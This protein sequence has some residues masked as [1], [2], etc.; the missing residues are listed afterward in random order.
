MTHAD[1]VAI[2]VARRIA[3]ECHAASAMARPQS[4]GD[5]VITAYLGGYC[6]SRIV[7][8]FEAN[9]FAGDLAAVVAEQM[10]DELRSVRPGGEKL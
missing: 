2:K 8:Y 6:L 9:Q 5:C 4:K 3:E 1:Q 10:L 7:S